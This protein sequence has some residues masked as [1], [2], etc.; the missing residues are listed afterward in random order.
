MMKRYRVRISGRVQGVCFRANAWEQARSLGLTG[1]VRNL[2]DGR[3]EAL[4]EGE[5]S[6][7]AA[8][9][10]WCGRGSPPARVDRL[11]VDE[12]HPKGE[13]SDFQILH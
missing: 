4:F 1:W 3:V 9:R 11:E 6:A 2:P 10:E 8:M 13:F 5:A 12:E 7:A